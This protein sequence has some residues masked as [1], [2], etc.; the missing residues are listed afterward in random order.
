MFMVNTKLST[1][2]EW[3]TANGKR[4]MR[5]HG[6]LVTSAVCRKQNLFS[7]SKNKPVREKRRA[8]G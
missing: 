3:E 6:H 2:T 8:S 7:L 5:N 1:F 4:Q